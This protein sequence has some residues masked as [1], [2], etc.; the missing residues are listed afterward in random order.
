MEPVE[1]RQRQR[2]VAEERPQ[3]IAVE[4]DA[5]AVGLVRFDLQ[6]FDDPQGDVADDEE[7]HQLAAR[8]TLLQFDT[9]AA[10]A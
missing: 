2:C 3:R 4:M 1:E 7:R 6:R 8:F 5:V 10:A 9:V